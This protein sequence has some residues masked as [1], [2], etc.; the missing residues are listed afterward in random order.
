MN[1]SQIYRTPIFVYLYI[2][3]SRTTDIGNYTLNIWFDLTLIDMSINPE[4]QTANIITTV[5]YGG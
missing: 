1:A 4:D 3:M 2:C 5:I